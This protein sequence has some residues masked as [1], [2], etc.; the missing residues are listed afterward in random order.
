MIWK[1]LSSADLLSSFKE[2]DISE[3]DK[4]ANIESYYNGNYPKRFIF[5]I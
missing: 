3:M 2:I 4:I 1:Y 5:I